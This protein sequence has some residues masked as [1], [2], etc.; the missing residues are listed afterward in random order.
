MGKKKKKKKKKWRL[1]KQTYWPLALYLKLQ[2]IPPLPQYAF[3]AWC[4]VKTK[5]AQG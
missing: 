3:I 4:S 5:K 1:L 2:A